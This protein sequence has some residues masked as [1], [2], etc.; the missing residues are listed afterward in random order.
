MDHL[1]RLGNSLSITIPPDENRI[2]GRECPQPNCEGYF[3]IELAPASRITGCHAIV[4]TAVT[5]LDMITL[6]QG[7]NQ[8]RQVGGEAE[9][10]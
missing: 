8:I 2:T 1:R 7:T 3:K 6:D 10:H 9:D 4:P 5:Y